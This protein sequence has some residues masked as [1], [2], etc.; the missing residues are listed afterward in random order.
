MAL[1]FANKFLKYIINI[2]NMREL[3]QRAHIL[4]ANTGTRQF[5]DL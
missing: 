2:P 5:I 3:Q 1:N 4:T